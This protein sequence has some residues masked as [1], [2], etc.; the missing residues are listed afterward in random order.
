MVSEAEQRYH[1]RNMSCNSGREI[2]RAR[3]DGD[4]P[5]CEHY[6]PGYAIAGDEVGGVGSAG[7]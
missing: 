2:F 4:E 5:Y 6:M 7:S 3:Q 1:S